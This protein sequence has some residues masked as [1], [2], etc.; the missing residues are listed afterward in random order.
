ML[1]KLGKRTLVLIEQYHMIPF[2]L[3]AGEHFNTATLMAAKPNGDVRQFV[4]VGKSDDG[5]AEKLR[6]Q[7]FDVVEGLDLVSAELRGFVLSRVRPRS[8]G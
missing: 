7:V 4:V 1:S 3:N 6:G 5:W 8:E 2:T